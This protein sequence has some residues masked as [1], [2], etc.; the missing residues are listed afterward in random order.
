MRVGAFFL[1][2]YIP[3]NVFE[4]KFA[5][6]Q[7]IPSDFMNK[8]GFSFGIRAKWQ[9]RSLVVSNFKEGFIKKQT[10]WHMN[11]SNNSDN[12]GN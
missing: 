5:I 8:L 1:H 11:I 3:F 12:E 6:D 7:T 4:A 9:F 2:I 10:T